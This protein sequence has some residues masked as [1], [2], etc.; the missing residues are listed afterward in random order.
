M[1]KLWSF[2]RQGF[3]RLWA[4]VIGR[5]LPAPRGGGGGTPAAPAPEA[6]WSASAPRLTTRD[7]A[8]KAEAHR[9]LYLS[10][11]KN[12]MPPLE[13]KRWGALCRDKGATFEDGSR[14]G[15]PKGVLF[16]SALVREEVARIVLYLPHTTSPAA[17]PPA[18][19]LPREVS[20]EAVRALVESLPRDK[21]EWDVKNGGLRPKLD[22]AVPAGT[23][24]AQVLSRI[25]G[26]PAQAVAP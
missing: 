13:R 8:R 24:L 7:Y 21:V 22:R 17:S 5:V 9:Q 18:A 23:V 20:Q 1:R 19:P 26:A 15:V 3:A 10:G 16:P 4:L 14:D 6:Y 2:V 11:E 25:P 12:W